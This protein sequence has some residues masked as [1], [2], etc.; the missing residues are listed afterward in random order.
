MNEAVC[1]CLY[2]TF[3]KADAAVI[4]DDPYFKAAC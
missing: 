3:F 4:T 2:E 1:Q